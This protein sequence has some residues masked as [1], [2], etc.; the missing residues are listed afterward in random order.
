MVTGRTCPWTHHG[1]ITDPIL[2]EQ[3]HFIAIGQANA[4]G[5]SEL[6]SM[7]PELD[8]I[9]DRIDSLTI[10]TRIDG[11]ASCVSRVV[12]ELGQNE[13]AHFACHGLPNPTQP[14]DFTFA[15]HDEHFTIQWII[16][17]DLKNPEFAYLSVCHTTVG[18]KE[19]L[20]EVIHLASAM[21]F[22]GFHS[23][24]GT[25]WTVDD[26]E[27]TKIMSPFYKHMV[28]ESDRL[29][30]AVIHQHLRHHRH[31]CQP[32]TTHV[33][34]NIVALQVQS[35]FAWLCTANCYYACVCRSWS[36]HE[37]LSNLWSKSSILGCMSTH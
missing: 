37:L 19:S 2:T 32:R 1:D 26:G 21:Q 13:W 16:G 17:H 20:D 10:F 14:F 4:A 25:M 34:H 24:I 15:M 6:P 29:D 18:D 33:I 23:I 28:D 31:L 22:A 5:E 35:G 8:N 30:H 27:M 7:G 36:I 9:R 12:D 3:K 11:E